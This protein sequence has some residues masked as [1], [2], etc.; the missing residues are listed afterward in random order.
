[1]KKKIFIYFGSI[2][3]LLTV[4]LIYWFYFSKPNPF[5]TDEQLVKEM[6]SLFPE[7]SAS[8]IQE[9]I[10]LDK[11][12]AFV[13]FISEEDHYGISFWVWKHH[14]WMVEFM[15]TN[16]N[17]RVWKINNNDPSTYHFVW[18]SASSEQLNYMNLYL[19]KKR[20]YYVTDNV[21]HYFPG[22]Q[23]EEKIS[24]PKTTYGSLP[25]SNEWVSVI[26]SLNKLNSAKQPDPFFPFYTPQQDIYFGWNTID[27]SDEITYPDR[28]LNSSTSWNGDS[29]IEYLL[30]INDYSELEYPY[31]K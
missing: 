25:I 5:P 22:V 20:N 12:H 6:N 24:L 16:G 7:V 4:V 30:F 26:D 23:M 11:E 14:K 15:D 8:I 28:N 2:V 3:F 18:N 1:M 9:V 21:H 31:Q 29:N 17:V 19:I 13:P 10:Y 27:K